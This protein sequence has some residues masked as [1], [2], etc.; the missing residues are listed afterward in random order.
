MGSSSHVVLPLL[1]KEGK[2][3]EEERE[4]ARGEKNG[5]KKLTLVG[6]LI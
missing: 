2:K 1:R 4:E 5:V 6:R 3:K